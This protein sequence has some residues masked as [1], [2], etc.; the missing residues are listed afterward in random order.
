MENNSDDVG[1]ISQMIDA[2]AQ[3]YN[4]DTKR[5]YATGHSNGSMMAYRLACELSDKITAIAPN[6]GQSVIEGCKQSRPVPILHFHGTADKCA[7]YNGGSECGGCFASMMGGLGRFMK[8]DTWA[9][10]PV[11]ESLAAHAKVNG[12]SAETKIIFTQ[13][14]TICERWQGCPAGASVTL[15]T[16]NG[17]GHTWARTNAGETGGKF[18]ADK[19]DSK[20]CSKM[21]ETVGPPNY[22]FD[23]SELM[24]KFFSQYVLP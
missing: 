6:A 11:P 14:D 18:C 8:H 22:D 17:A 4:I 5:V 20:F 3:N 21:Q 15:C 12:C 10:D 13:G 1:F 19:P 16:M 24:W 7:L 9:C 23:A 2:M